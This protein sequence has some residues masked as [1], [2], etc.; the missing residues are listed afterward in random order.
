M[1][2]ALGVA[3][4]GATPTVINGF[5]A[6]H[7]GVSIDEVAHARKQ[8]DLLMNNMDCLKKEGSSIT[9]HDNTEIKAAICESGAIWILVT[10]VHDQKGFE[11]I[12]PSDLIANKHAGIP[13]ISK[14]N[15]QS[16]PIILAAN[17]RVLCVFKDKSGKVIRR[18][19]DGLGKCHDEQIDPYTGAVTTVVANC[20]C[21]Q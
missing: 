19:T 17:G 6:L 16:L 15:A 20:P 1:Y 9:L 3:V 11:W 18:I 8:N 10:T 13:L 5:Q 7:I 14:A 2:P 12:N 21:P 4:L